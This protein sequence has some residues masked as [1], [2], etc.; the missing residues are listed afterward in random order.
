MRNIGPVSSLAIC[1]SLLASPVIAQDAATPAQQDDIPAQTESTA[2]ADTIVVLASRMFGEVEAPQ[3]PLLEL[4]VEEIAAYGSGSIAE[5]LEAIAPQVSSARGRGDGGGPVILV[6]GV[7]ISSFR[8]LRSYPPEA[9]EK[10]EVFAEEVA[11][12]YGYSPDQRV[13]NFILKDNYQSREIELEYGQPWDGGYSTQEVEA[14]YLRIDGPSRLNLNLEWNNSSSLTEGER[15]VIQSTAPVAP[16][17][18][19]PADFRT[20]VADTASLEGTATWTTTLGD[21]GDSLSINGSVDRSDSLRLQGLSALSEPLEV[22]RRSTSYSAGSTLNMGLG[23]W[24]LTGTVDGTHAESRSFIDIAG[25]PGTLLDPGFEEARS[26]TDRIESVATLRGSPFY[27]PAG[28][29][30]LTLAARYVWNRIQSTD[31][32]NP[33]VETSLSRG[34]T[35]G[36]ANISVPLTSRRDNV[37]SAVGDISLN[38]SF[39]VDHLSDFGTLTDWSAGLTWGVTDTLTFSASHIARDTAPSLTQLGSPEIATFNVPVY[40]LTNNETVLVTVLDGGNPALPEQSQRDWKFGAVWD[41][42]F[43]ERSNLSVDYI[44]NKSTDVASSFPILTPVIEAAFPDR[45]TRAADGTLLQIDQRPVTFARQNVER[46]QFGLNLSGSISSDEGQAA[47]GDGAQGRG[48]R[49]GPATMAGDGPPAGGPPGG[50]GGQAAARDPERFAAMRERFCGDEGQTLAQRLVE[51]EANGTLGSDDLAIPPQMLERF[52][53]DDGKIDPAR[54]N[55][56]RDRVCSSDGPPAGPPGGGQGAGGPPGAGAGAGGGGFRG[57]LGRMA[58]GGPPGGGRWF[59]NLQYTLDL[60]NKVLV[61]EGGPLLDLLDGDAAS[62]G[63]SPR[64][65]ANARAGLFKDGYGVIASASY[66]GSARLDGTGLPGSTDLRFGDYAT[67][68]VRTFFNFDSQE[69]LVAK[70]PLLKGTRISFDIEN[71]FDSRQKVTDST[72]TVPLRYQPFL[73]DPVGRSFE[74]ELRKL[75]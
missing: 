15:G 41:L 19:D 24:Q 35:A 65:S 18:L 5:L 68:D 74:I 66:V 9:I 75:F 26:K 38:G 37:L 11:Q 49:G 30:S 27:L 32:R 6:N 52:R 55:A 8:E 62:G 34:R 20:L 2:D 39:G 67:L 1:T 3:P 47:D 72:G 36:S 69:D 25:E 14:T 45:V 17:E 63:T 50:A 21:S 12:R 73:V 33:G 56:F 43:L 71:I 28:D 31:T 42:P 60:E 59:A 70:V 54:V 53:G 40:D 48:N 57:G 22:D 23:D 13:V 61:A 10:V 7:R 58:R 16:G 46:L 64:H 51:A 4:G 44:R 29:V